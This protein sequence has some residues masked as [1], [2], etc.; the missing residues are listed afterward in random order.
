MLERDLEALFTE[1]YFYEGRWQKY[2][3]VMQHSRPDQYASRRRSELVCV[4]FFLNHT[5]AVRDDWTTLFLYKNE[6]P[7]NTEQ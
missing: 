3:T 2:F 6:Q 7:H 4:V 1:L 5:S